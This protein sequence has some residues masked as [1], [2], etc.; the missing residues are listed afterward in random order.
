[1]SNVSRPRG[2]A[3]SVL[4]TDLDGTLIPL[5]DNEQNRAD[6]QALTLALRAK[7]VT[8]AFVTGRHLEIV[9]Q[10]IAEH[11]L[12]VPDWIIC[13]VGTTIYQQAGSQWEEVADYRDHLAS[14]CAALPTTALQ[15][16]LADIEGLTLQEEPKQGRFK[17]SYYV[18]QHQLDPIANVVAE[19][20][21]RQDA[22]WSLISSV[23]P[24]TQDG[25]IDLLPRD[26]SKAH[27]IEWW[28]RHCG[29]EPEQVVF[30]G[31]SGNDRAALIAGYRAIIVSNA[32]PSLVESVQQHHAA[33]GWTDRLHLSATPATSGVLEGCG[34]FGLV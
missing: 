25:L 9:V 24:F 30:A 2:T 6:L 12:P 34:A 16:T 14:L 32:P 5:A 23:D 3:A 7:D 26:V 8:L 1:M 4:A 13:D 33:Q 17:L 11:D 18:D 20:L 15:L 27:A 19:R 31:D 22:P 10:A 21:A 28:R 29:F